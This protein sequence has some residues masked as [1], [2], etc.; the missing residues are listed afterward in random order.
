MN[1]F[2]FEEKYVE[3]KSRMDFDQANV[4][5][6]DSERVKP[7][8]HQ[9]NAIGANRRQS[10]LLQLRLDCIE[11]QKR[12]QAAI[13]ELY[14]HRFKKA[15]SHLMKKPKARVFKKDNQDEIGEK[16]NLWMKIFEAQNS[17]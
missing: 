7:T 3:N 12:C 9:R 5:L 6:A 14:K 1:H 15:K 10:T 4:D 13:H 16:L 11:H 8:W 17:Q 2:L